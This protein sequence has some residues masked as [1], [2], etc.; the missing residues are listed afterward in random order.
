MIEGHR[1]QTANGPQSSASPHSACRGQDGDESCYHRCST[2][3]LPRCHVRL[4]EYLPL[5]PQISEG[6]LDSLDRKLDQVGRIMDTLAAPCHT[7][8]GTELSTHTAPTHGTST[9]RSIDR[10]STSRLAIHGKDPPDSQ[11]I[12]GRR[13]TS[14]E[15]ADERVVEGLSSLSANSK[16]AIDL[17]HRVAGADLEQGYNFETRD[18]LDRLQ[19]IV[20]AVKGNRMT[21]RQSFTTAL[22]SETSTDRDHQTMPPIQAAVAVIQ[23][24][25][26]TSRPP[27]LS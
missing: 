25:Q 27:L 10:S 3:P 17:M 22:L 20:G 2:F 11:I 15:P 26:G 23:K 21:R 8:D 13:E 7:S 12:S 24:A 14:I 6:K 19:Q 5:P 4:T 1:A 18:L 9:P 16:F